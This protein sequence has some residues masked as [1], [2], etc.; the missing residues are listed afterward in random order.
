MRRDSIDLRR[1]AARY[2][3]PHI[4][5]FVL[6]ED[7]CEALSDNIIAARLQIAAVMLGIFKHA[8][9]SLIVIC[10]RSFFSCFRNDHCHNDYSFEM[11]SFG[12]RIALGFAMKLE[13]QGRERPT[14]EPMGARKYR[15]GSPP[16]IPGSLP[17]L[18]RHSFQHAPS[19]HVMET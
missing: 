5:R 11:S 7:E 6:A 8:L 19:E 10:S 3:K 12:M 13:G 17:H 9:L 2:C 14:S 18:P 1:H 15:A 4:E 16:R